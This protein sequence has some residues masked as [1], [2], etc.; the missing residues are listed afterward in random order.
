M[1]VLR[2]VPE[3]MIWGYFAPDVPPVMRVESG[4]VVDIET[5]NGLGVPPED[6]EGFFKRHGLPFDDTL[7][8]LAQ[9]LR[10]LRKDVGP[11]LLTGPIYIEDAQ[12]GDVLEVRVVSVTP[13]P[14]YYGVS[15]TRPD[16]GALP[17]LV[18]KPWLK[19]IRIDREQGLARFAPGV[20]IPLQPF[21]GIMAV[22]PTEKV[23]S[24][25]PGK[26][27]GNIDLKDLTAGARLY[28]PVQVP[29]ALFFTGDGH[30]AQGDGEVN[31]TGL[32]TSMVTRLQ[33]VLHKQCDQTWPLAETSDHYIVMGLDE[34]LDEAARIAVEQCVGALQHFAGMSRV[35]AYSA[36]SLLVD[37]ALTQ[38]VDGVKGVH[39]RI[40]K[41]RF[42]MRQEPWWGPRWR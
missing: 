30:G 22:A 1:P 36:S 14:P 7:Q 39:G 2:S 10:A 32:E 41:Q 26:F 6:P 34:D 40:P 28:L 23:S 33:F 9:A 27:G 24:I 8:Q 20:D 11:H 3:N 15:F 38:I 25:P 16:G 21:M 13:R 5:F 31:L 18:D 37:F 4:A 19:V 42:T 17:G 12:P 35:D 29:G